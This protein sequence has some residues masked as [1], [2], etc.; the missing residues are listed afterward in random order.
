MQEKCVCEDCSPLLPKLVP[1]CPWVSSFSPL[2][3]AA[4]LLPHFQYTS[5]LM[6][7]NRD[8]WEVHKSKYKMWKHMYV[9]A[10]ERCSSGLYPK[11][12]LTLLYPPQHSYRVYASSRL[13]WANDLAQHGCL[14]RQ[15]REMQEFFNRTLG[16]QD[17]FLGGTSF[18]WNHAASFLPSSPSQRRIRVVASAL[19][20]SHSLLQ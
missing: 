15:S 12:K 11:P 7:S 6:P 13:L 2:V 1:Q 20:P 17:S 8:T 19:S 14:R 9:T 4:I 10:V 18:F 3:L 5:H 16:L